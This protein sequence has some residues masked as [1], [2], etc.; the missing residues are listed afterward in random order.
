MLKARKN[1]VSYRQQAREMGVNQRYVCDL[2][3]RGKEPTNPKVRQRMGL[4]PLPALKL[5]MACPQCGEVHVRKTCTQRKPLPAWVT[6]GADFLQEREL[7]KPPA[8]RPGA[9]GEHGGRLPRVTC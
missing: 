6:R 2:A 1:G 5:A 9:R 8:E 7:N 4:P 3:I